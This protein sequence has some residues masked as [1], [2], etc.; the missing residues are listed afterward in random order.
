MT[1]LRRLWRRE[2]GHGVGMTVFSQQRASLMLY[3]YEADRREVQAD[4]ASRHVSMTAQVR[5][6]VVAF[7]RWGS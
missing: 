4:A 3:L 7:L 5:E 2:Q 6:L 1:P